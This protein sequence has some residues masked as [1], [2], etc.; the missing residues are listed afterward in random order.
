MVLQIFCGV[1]NFSFI[2]TL[3]L[4]G[5]WCIWLPKKNLKRPELKMFRNHI[6]PQKCFS[7]TY[8]VNSFRQI[9]VVLGDCYIQSQ[10]YTPDFDGVIEYQLCLKC[11]LPQASYQP[12]P[13]QCL[14]RP[15]DDAPSEGRSRAYCSFKWEVPVTV[16]WLSSLY[17]TGHLEVKCTP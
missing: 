12:H 3:N 17:P 16:G 6:F 9:K 15:I 4:N 11:L 13:C 2:L 1:F 5:Q 10:E 8:L 7:D 14:L